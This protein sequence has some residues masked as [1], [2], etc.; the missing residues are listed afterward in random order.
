MKE[1]VSSHKMT[2]RS[3][4]IRELSN[5]LTHDYIESMK[6]KTATVLIERNSKGKAFGYT[7]QYIPVTIANHSA[8]LNS[9]VDVILTET[10]NDGNE[11]FAKAIAIK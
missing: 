9:F 11:F 6:G 4:I 5:N 7:Q 8:P 2:H 1:Q 3:S 10:A